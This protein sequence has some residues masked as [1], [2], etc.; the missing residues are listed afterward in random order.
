MYEV[1]KAITIEGYD[2]VL[3]VW[4]LDDLQAGWRVLVVQF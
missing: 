4:E 2:R 1:I 3:R